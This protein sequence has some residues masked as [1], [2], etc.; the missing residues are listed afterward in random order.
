ML[1]GGPITLFGI[2]STCR[3][4]GGVTLRSITVRLSGAA[5]GTTRAAPLT[6]SILFSFPET[7]IWAIAAL[8]HTSGAPARQQTCIS[9]IRLLLGSR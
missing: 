6:R 4:R 5:F 2:P 3:T 1:V 7:T 8:A 9:F